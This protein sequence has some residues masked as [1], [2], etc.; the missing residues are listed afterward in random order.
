MTDRTTKT[1]RAAESHAMRYAVAHH[2]WSATGV[3]TPPL[4][5]PIVGQGRF[6]HSF[7]HWLHLVDADAEQF[8]QVFALIAQWGVGKSRLGYELLAQ[9]ND[10]SRGWW[11]RDDATGQLVEA[12]LFDEAEREQYLGLYI[13]YS[14]VANE[15]HNVDN[16]FA[17]GLY[18]A[19]VPLATNTIDSSIQGTIAK[20][21]ADRLF[22][23]GFEPA[24]LAVALEV[25]KK[26]SDEDLY[27]NP[28]LVTGLCNAAYDYLTQFGI[29]YVMVVLDELE[30]AAEAATFGMEGNDLKHLDGRAIKLMGKAIK[31]EDPRRKLPWLRYVALCSPAIGDELREIR[32]TARR[33]ETDELSANSFADVSDFV[34]RLRQDGRLETAYPTGLVEAAYAMSG[35]N[36]GWFNVIMAAVDERL[37]DWK[38]KTV[39]IGGLFDNLVQVSERIRRYVLD[40]HAFDHV[41]VADK[42]LR[43]RIRDLCYGQLPIAVSLLP[44][45]D[46]ESILKAGNEYDEPVALLFRRVEWDVLQAADALRAA[47]FTRDQAVYRLSGVD[48]PID[49]RQ[50]FAN[51]S[52]FAIHTQ[53]GDNAQAKLAEG[54]H[55]SG[56]AR[57][58]IPL[59]Q[60]EFIELLQLLYPHPAAEDAG[61]A[62]WKGLMGGTD[63]VPEDATHIGPSMAMIARLDLRHRRQ[64][65]SAMAFRD[66]DANNAHELALKAVATQRDAEKARHVVVGAMRV[67]D[68]Q[69]PYE[70]VPAGIRDDELVAIST[71]HRTKTNP[72]GGL[73]LC[74][75]LKLHPKGRLIIAWVR[76]AGELTRLAEGA[77]TLFGTEGRIPVVAL[78][79]SRALVDIMANNP[80][81]VLAE[82]KNFILL[83]QL[84]ASEE[85]LLH[86]VGLPATAQAGFQLQQGVFSSAF[87]QRLHSFRR[88]F[89]AAV[90]EWRV[91]LDERGMIAWPLRPGS[92]M[93]EAEIKLLT[94]AWSQ[95]LFDE[96]FRA[97]PGTLRDLDEKSGLNIGE[98]PSALR[99][100]EISATARSRGYRDSERSG[101]FS[102]IDDSAQAVM[103]A[104]LMRV[105][106]RM[107]V[108][109]HPWTL[110]DAERAWFWGYS[111]EGNKPKDVY[112]D[113]MSLACMAGFAQAMASDPTGEGYEVVGRATLR[114]RITE[115]DN[116]LNKPYAAIVTEMADVFGEGTVNQL[117]RPLGT[118]EPG[119]KTNAAKK[120]IEACSKLV[121]Q[122]DKEES[123][124]SD[125]LASTE[126]AETLVR[127]GYQRNQ[128][129]KDVSWVYHKES[130]EHLR[131]ENAKTLVFTDDDEPLWRRIRRA[132]LFMQTVLAV[133]ERIRKRIPSLQQDMK[134]AAPA[135]FPI[136]LFTLSLAK[137]AHILDGALGG[138]RDAKAGTSA[139]TELAQSSEPG[140]LRQHLRDL[141]I[142]EAMRQL[143]H[144][145]NEVGCEVV[146]G[147]DKPLDQITGAIAEGYRQLRKS[148]DALAA[149]IADIRT[150]L[151]TIQTVIADIT[152]FQLDGRAGHPTALLT[153]LDRVQDAVMTAAE[154]DAE[155]LRADHDATAKLGQFGLLMKAAERLFETPNAS[156]G[157]LL[158]EVT[159]LENM[160][161]AYRQRLLATP[162]LIKAY[163]AVEALCRALREPPP[164]ALTMA[165]LERTT[166]GKAMA[167]V[168]ATT[169]SLRSTGETALAGTSMSFDRWAIIVQTVQAGEEPAWDAGEDERL[170]KKGLLRRTY[171]LGG[172]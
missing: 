108:D 37:R 162:D 96:R 67:I 132:Q 117:F 50:L 46:R 150:R 34:A 39:T 78:T 74:D 33:F 41:T 44:A 18:K 148:F 136:Q 111:W 99:K 131:E 172:G 40:H 12:R 60:A 58:L 95:L 101:I 56:T 15:F 48:Q 145:A 81:K 32:S 154:D 85:H 35:G 115:A 24:K 69:W 38:G 25:A 153:K 128:V 155:S 140:T 93:K 30:T 23:K 170:V 105:I 16:W 63:L 29:R 106:K 7:R 71:A 127:W 126:A 21:A 6:F 73:V 70:A 144:L 47:K 100:Y 97:K 83:Y 122:L 59:R 19:L 10:T 13:R 91:G 102:C 94:A 28:T 146:G 86:Q 164:V 124:A 141:Q 152:D 112:L 157:G 72:Q 89:A 104:F 54:Q 5:H 61:R 26:H 165:D 138:S 8:A 120:R 77:S 133:A 107:L 143:E 156:A 45:G 169:A 51:L 166:L 90:V 167:L 161:L 52:T 114:N 125:R 159:T 158:G 92:R 129:T 113:W 55:S 17:F 109:H 1:P 103:P 130:W 68:E 123:T 134:D 139:G 64:A 4:K 3:A 98:L 147:A 53:A 119:T 49:L 76:N 66:P 42:A 65:L 27:E 62:L 9:I 168:T 110:R 2:H 14:Q 22:T 121:D 118:T 87:D 116:W 171:R 31:E 20:E 57:L 88:Q 11:I 82:A 75:G 80:A 84:S 135:G 43:D 36:F 149:R 160:V 142:A 137:I 151:T 79:T 163:H